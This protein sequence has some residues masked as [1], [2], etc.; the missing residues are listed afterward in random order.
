MSRLTESQTDDFMSYGRID[1]YTEQGEATV[2]ACHPRHTDSGIVSSV[3]LAQAAK[4]VVSALEY[5]HRR[6]QH[7]GMKAQ[8]ALLLTWVPSGQ[9]VAGAARAKAARAT[10]ATREAKAIAQGKLNLE[11]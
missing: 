9:T 10:K 5:R 7:T 6:L 3:D 8:Q 11:R 4:Q 1:Q 2:I